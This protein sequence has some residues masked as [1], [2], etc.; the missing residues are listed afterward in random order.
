[1]LANLDLRDMFSFN[2]KYCED[3]HLDL[4]DFKKFAFDIFI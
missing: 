2:C 3:K 4:R 1:M